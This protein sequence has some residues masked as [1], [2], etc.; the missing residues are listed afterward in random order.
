MNSAL[1]VGDTAWCVFRTVKSSNKSRLLNGFVEMLAEPHPIKVTVLN[2]TGTETA[3][4]R[5]TE[6]TY[7]FDDEWID[8]SNKHPAVSVRE[9]MLVL[10]G[11]FLTKEKAEEYIRSCLETLSTWTIQKPATIYKASSGEV[12]EVR[13]RYIDSY[14]DNIEE[15]RKFRYNGTEEGVLDPAPFYKVLNYDESEFGKSLFISKEEAVNALDDRAIM[16]PVDPDVRHLTDIF[17]C[18]K[19]GSRVHL[20]E[21]MKEYEY[22]FCPNCGRPIY[23]ENE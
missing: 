3:T 11:I 6:I 1:K 2:F 8:S 22:E 21:Y 5:N 19:C 4:T 18:S 15:E 13:I 9:D 10:N 23:S 14:I 20:G 12:T 16:K 7:R 17:E